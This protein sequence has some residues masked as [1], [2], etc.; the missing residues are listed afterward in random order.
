MATTGKIG[1]QL[2]LTRS[3]L[4]DLIQV[5]RKQG[6]S[7]L[8]PRVAEGAVSLLPIESATQLPKG[9]S[10]EQ[11]GGSYRIV[12]GEPELTFQYV[13]GPDGPK[14]Y[15]FPPNL[16]LFQFHVE[17]DSFV[18]DVGPPQVSKL[19]MLGVRACELAAIEVQDRVFGM[20][21]P[22]MFRCESE[23]WYT[24][25]RQEALLIA[26]NCTRPSGTCFCAAWG[27]GPAAT[28]GFDLALTELRDGFLVQVGS[29]RGAALLDELPVREPTEAEIE[30]AKIKL[31]RARERMGR[32]LDIGG[33]KEL[34]DQSIEYPEWD[35]VA[36]PLPFLRQL[37]DGLPHLLLL[38]CHRH[39]RPGGDQRGCQDA[40]VGIVFYPPVY[41]HHFRAGAEHHPRPLP[42]LAAA[43]IVHLVGAIRLQRLRGLRAVHHVVSRRHRS[44]RGGPTPPGTEP[45]PR[46]PRGGLAERRSEPWSSQPLIRVRN[47]FAG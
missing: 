19:A 37:H 15:L 3:A 47:P 14:R 18:L 7:V 6:Y 30:L 44:D 12:E 20:D 2:Y 33:L 17:A 34:L 16:Q 5:L 23:P 45:C 32:Q 11:D 25:I 29:K 24:Q 10:D 35:E 13:V 36:Q 26:V 43:Q 1:S 41:L 21:D 9:V 22:R 40:T 28:K 42:A 31:E 39:D 38:H 27:T 4:D 8:G 46:R